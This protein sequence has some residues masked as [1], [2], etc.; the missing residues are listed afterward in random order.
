MSAAPVPS[1]AVATIDPDRPAIGKLPPAIQAALELRKM[2]NLVAPQVAGLNWGKNLDR[3]TARA[4]A[5]WCHRNDV[6]P[7]TE[8][9]VLGGKVYRNAAWHLR[10]PG[11]LIEAGR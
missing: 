5:D 6:E 9:E 10:K 1:K 7:L 11:E 8:V 4:V 3:A 2:Q